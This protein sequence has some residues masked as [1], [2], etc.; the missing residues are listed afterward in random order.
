MIKWMLWLSLTLSISIF[1]ILIFVLNYKEILITY[2]PPS[3]CQVEDYTISKF[4]KCEITNCACVNTNLMSC[5]E[6]KSY[7]E[8]LFLNFISDIKPK[9]GQCNNGYMCCSTCCSTCLRTSCSNGSCRTSSYVCNCHCCRSVGNSLCENKCLENYFV[10]F[11]VV[12]LKMN[13]TQ[14][15]TDTSIMNNFI[16]DH[17]KEFNCYIDDI[18]NVIYLTKDMT[19]WKVAMLS[20]SI[21]SIIII[22][23]LIALNCVYPDMCCVDTFNYR[24]CDDCRTCDCDSCNC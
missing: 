17:L 16:E 15:F 3:T 22:L 20:L 14:T 5:S 8:N 6:S 13:F 2:L 12:N 23:I 1:L 9:E 11:S 21:L 24:N 10:N 4:Y 7:S 18:D 19:P